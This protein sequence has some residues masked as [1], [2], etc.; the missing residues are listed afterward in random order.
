MDQEALMAWQARVLTLAQQEDLS[1]FSRETLDEDWIR[2]LVRLSFF[3]SGP[4]LAVEF[5]NKAGIHLVVLPHLPKTYLDGACMVAPW[6]NPVIGMTLR[7]DRLDHFWF[8]LLHE[9]AHLYLHLNQD[10]KVFFDQIEP[11]STEAQDPLER[12]ANTFA[13]DYL[14]PPQAWDSSS[15][16]LLATTRSEPLA[17]FAGE[18]RISPAIVAGRVRRELG[19]YRIHNSLVGQKAVR[20]QFE[21]YGR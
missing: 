2:E 11:R 9:L 8:T 18:L 5:L 3:S 20:E 1:S 14:I 10:G 4:Q 7:Y 13:C 19:N 16:T 6:G 17:E 15:P 21:G 12:E